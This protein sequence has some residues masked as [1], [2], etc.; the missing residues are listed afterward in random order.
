[1]YPQKYVNAIKMQTMFVKT[2]VMQA[3]LFYVKR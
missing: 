3:T 2:V 1:M